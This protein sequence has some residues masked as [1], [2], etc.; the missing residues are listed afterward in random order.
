MSD[1]TILNIGSPFW[2]LVG[3]LLICKIYEK[4]EQKL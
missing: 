2:G 3:G 4:K 1:L